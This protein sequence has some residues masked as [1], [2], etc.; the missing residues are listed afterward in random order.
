MWLYKKNDDIL[1]WPLCAIFV[2]ITLHKCAPTIKDWISVWEFFFIYL[3]TQNRIY[4]TIIHVHIIN[5]LI[6]DSTK[7]Y[8]IC[9]YCGDGTE[10]KQK[11]NSYRLEIWEISSPWAHLLPGKYIYKH[12]NCTILSFYFIEYKNRDIGYKNKYIL[13]LEPAPSP[14]YSILN[15]LLLQ[16]VLNCCINFKSTWLIKYTYG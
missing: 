12:A 13:T 11:V 15:L 9:Y 4:S 10:L 2:A 5:K 3:K 14:P 8:C 6:I 7:A 1:H 16:L